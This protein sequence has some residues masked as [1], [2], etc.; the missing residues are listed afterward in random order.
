MMKPITPLDFQHMRHAEAEIIEA[1]MTIL[2]VLKTIVPYGV[3][4]ETDIADEIDS[5]IT[6]LH[7]F[8]YNGLYA[9]YDTDHV[10]YA[11]R[12]INAPKD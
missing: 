12:E 8:Y 7:E 4:V 9:K 10:I 2:R 11:D 5:K 3:H 1:Q 6:D